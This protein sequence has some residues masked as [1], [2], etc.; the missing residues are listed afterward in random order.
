MVILFR[1]SFPECESVS[2]RYCWQIVCHPLT[3]TH[4][5]HRHHHCIRIWASCN[6]PLVYICYLSI[7]LSVVCWLFCWISRLRLADHKLTRQSW[8]S[9]TQVSSITRI[10]PNWIIKSNSLCVKRQSLCILALC[11]NGVQ[12]ASNFVRLWWQ[13]HVWIVDECAV[14]IGIA[15]ATSS[16][17]PIVHFQDTGH[18]APNPGSAES[19]VYVHP[20]HE[21]K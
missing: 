1:I 20:C 19:N 3:L 15:I 16:I 12:C 6:K 14:C 17:C 10:H 18:A 13:G 21:E 5:C 7:C 11:S 4:H 8:K 9:L 2:H